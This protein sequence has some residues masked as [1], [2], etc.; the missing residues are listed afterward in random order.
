MPHIRLLRRLAGHPLAE[1]ASP[2]CDPF[3]LIALYRK[4]VRLDVPGYDRA[5]AHDSAFTDGD[6]SHE[7]GVGADE[8]AA[9]D[10][11]PRLAET[12]VIAR[13]RA[14][15]DVGV[16]ADF[17]VAD[18]GQMV[19]LRAFRDLGFLELDK[20]SDLGLLAEARAGADPSERADARLGA[21]IG[22]LNV[23]EGVDGRAVGDL[24]ARP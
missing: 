17:R 2:A 16:R 21:D 19:D 15:A 8:G 1:A 14:G 7:G 6:G 20:I 4:A 11:R 24:D 9:A 18:V 3:L 5:R 13:D 22:A 12:V 10:D 23:A